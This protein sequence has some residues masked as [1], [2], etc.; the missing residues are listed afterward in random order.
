MI[1][2]RYFTVALAVALFGGAALTFGDVR[3]RYMQWEVHQKDRPQPPV[4]DPGHPGTQ[5]KPGKAPS[6]AVVLFDGKSTDALQ[7]SN[8][9][10]I[11]WRIT[12]DG[13]LSTVRGKGGAQSKQAFGDI[14][15]HVEWRTPDSQ[16]QRSGQGRG[17]SGIFLMGKYEVQ[18]LDNKGNETYPD[19]MAGSIYG[20]FP[21]LVNAGRGINQWQTYDIIFRRPHFNDDGSLKK[22]ATVTVLHNGVVVQD[23][24]ELLGPTRH[25]ARTN[26]SK[27]ADKL[28]IV[29]QNHGEEAH[30]RN[31]WVRELGPRND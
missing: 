2:S 4:V 6:D 18:V 14:Q 11:G 20:Q 22:P 27:H 7:Q 15:L 30:Y 23:N 17:N 25:K 28:P 10:P 5:D 1:R 21:P 31:V 9:Q 26:Y 3:E 19:G 8:G 13:A 29:F 12:E 16:A 24:Q